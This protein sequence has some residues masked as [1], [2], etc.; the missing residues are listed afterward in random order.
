MVELALELPGAFE[1]G[2]NAVLSGGVKGALQ[3]LI[4]ARGGIRVSL[5]SVFVVYFTFLSAC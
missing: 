1:Q 2:S 5:H 3:H 4:A